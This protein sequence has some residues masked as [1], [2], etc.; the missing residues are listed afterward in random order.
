MC[1]ELSDGEGLAQNP[2]DRGTG[3][4][5]LPSST[6]SHTHTPRSQPRQTSCLKEAKGTKHASASS[7]RKENVQLAQRQWALFFSPPELLQEVTL[8]HSWLIWFRWGQ[9]SPGPLNEPRTQA[10]PN[11][12]LV[13][14]ATKTGLGTDRWPHPAKQKLLWDVAGVMWKGHTLAPE[15]NFGMM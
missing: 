6:A 11:A 1:C 14:W 7:P 3:M 2:R 9:P 10:Y 13:S 4:E 8:P 5:N 12:T 15:V